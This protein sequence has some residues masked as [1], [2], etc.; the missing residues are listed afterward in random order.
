MINF[1][2]KTHTYTNIYGEIYSSVSNVISLY[3]KPFDSE[4]FSK[5]TAKKRGVSPEVIREEWKKN[6]EEACDYGKE[7]HSVIEGYLKGVQ[8]KTNSDILNSFC[9]VFPY[10][11]RDVSSEKILWNDD[12]KIAG[13]SDIIVDVNDTFFDVLDIKTNKKFDFNNKYGELLLKPL[14]HLQNC[15]YNT[16]S[17]QLSLYAYMYSK[18]TNK[19]PRNLAIL[20]WCRDSKTFQKY[21][22]P[23]MFW[24]VSVLL[25][26]YN[27][28][29]AINN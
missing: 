4:F 13:T 26:H 2:P 10:K 14:D 15:K 21:Y 29:P 22:T 3:K 28:R 7:V 20:Y 1:D 24:E 25:K 16:Y 23:Y 9:N 8:T 5:M 12:F 27:S 19:R 17:I 6:T 18:L 11:L